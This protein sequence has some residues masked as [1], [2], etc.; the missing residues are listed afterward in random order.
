MTTSV[1]WFRRDLRLGDHPALQAAAADGHVV[2]L[3]VL[4]PR[5]AGSGRRWGR[6]LASLAALREEMEG[7]LVIRQG[8]PAEVVAQVAAEAGASR[9]HIST[10]TTPYGRRRDEAV[11]QRLADAGIGLVGTGS[12]YAVTPGRVRNATGAPYRVFTPFLRAWREHGWR[13]PAGDPQVEWMTKLESDPLP[14]HPD[15]LDQEVGEQAALHRWEDFCAEELAGYAT[16]RDR[17]D[18]N[19]TSRLSTA[20]KFGE[21]HPRTLLA[22]LG[23]HG[24]GASAE[25]VERFVAELAWR[26]FYADVLWHDPGSAWRDLR[27]SLRGMQ[28]DDA[29]ELLEA[30]KSGTTGFPFVDAGMRQLLAEG[31]MHNRVRMVVASFL[32]KDLHIWWPAGARHFLDHLLD[33]DLASNSHGWQWA[34]G[35]GT[36]AAPYFRV[37]NP[38]TQ[39]LRFDPQ[40]DYVRR[41][42]PELRHLPGEAAH[43]PWRHPEGFAKG[44]PERVVDHAEE[45]REALARLTELKDST[46]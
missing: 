18:L 9:V 41:W 11:E 42:V 10:E 1:M 28:Y 29:P 19:R 16:A 46:L 20:L 13:A 38:V 26:E 37:F 27:D 34:A 25:D 36:D 23:A 15:H 17:P 24:S 2:P 3:F 40:G 39:G 5:L 4:D 22:D 43:E 8:D 7:A 30:W 35:T 14:D 32:V 21:I 45:R 33:G 44:Y 6:L 31:W 12:P